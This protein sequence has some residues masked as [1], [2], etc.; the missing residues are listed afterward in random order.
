M[1][2]RKNIFKLMNNSVFEK[3]VEN[4]KKHRDIRFQ[5]KEEVIMWQNQTIT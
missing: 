3:T 5:I 1:I 4:L 2:L